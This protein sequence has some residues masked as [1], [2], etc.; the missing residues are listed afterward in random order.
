MAPLASPSL[1]SASPKAFP[2]PS[3]NLSVHPCLQLYSTRR[4]PTPF[5]M[6]ATVIAPT[7]RH[8]I[9]PDKPFN[10]ETGIRGLVI[11]SVWQGLRQGARLLIY[12]RYRGVSL[13]L[14]L[15]NISGFPTRTYES[16]R[17]VSFQG[18]FLLFW[19]LFL[20]DYFVKL[21]PSPSVP[22]THERLRLI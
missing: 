16:M 15:I 6:E 5:R 11:D 10:G 1:I 9:A 14:R 3:R 13:P 12:G 17:S 22:H 21:Q 18:L 7:F 20:L 4:A 8:S 2:K 19:A